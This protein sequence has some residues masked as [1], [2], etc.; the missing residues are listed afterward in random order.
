MSG[1]PPL[2][3]DSLNSGYRNVSLHIR[4]MHMVEV[5]KATYRHRCT[6][7]A[8]SAF[9]ATEEEEAQERRNSAGGPSAD[10]KVGVSRR[11]RRFPVPRQWKE[12]SRATGPH[13][14]PSGAPNS[15]QKAALGTDKQKSFHFRCWWSKPGL[16]RLRIVFK[17]GERDQEL[18]DETNGP[19][20]PSRIVY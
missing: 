7:I 8:D 9:V 13:S 5:T 4:S 1:L 17:S 14:P 2:G 15:F 10:I 12:S 18:D 20:I 3:F 6:H 11:G 16:C 19:I